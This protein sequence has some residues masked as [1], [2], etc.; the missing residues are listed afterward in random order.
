M[1]NIKTTLAGVISS[2]T[3]YITYAIFKSPPL[4]YFL[5]SILIF[6]TF[7][8]YERKLGS[9]PPKEI[10][11]NF[12]FSTLLSA[13]WPLIILISFNTFSKS[14]HHWILYVFAVHLGMY[15]NDF[16]ILHYK[17]TEK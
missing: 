3:A 9:E 6:L 11:E 13:S 4:D 16:I 17:N 2:S 7:L 12:I 14:D 10:P 8:I 5:Y 1:E 15:V